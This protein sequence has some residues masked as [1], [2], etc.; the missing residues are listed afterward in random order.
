MN[1]QEKT[2][3][4]RKQE[5]INHFINHTIWVFANEIKQ[6][7]PYDISQADITQYKDSLRGQLS[8]PAYPISDEEFDVIIDTINNHLK[9]FVI[10]LIIEDEQKRNPINNLNSVDSNNNFGDIEKNVHKM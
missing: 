8:I 10:Q 6:S 9:E 1:K 5:L 3:N 4:E 2:Y 7:Y